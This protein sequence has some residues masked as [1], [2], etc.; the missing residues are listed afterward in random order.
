MSRNYDAS[1]HHN[2]DKTAMFARQAPAT[3]ENAKA[4]QPENYIYES[5]IFLLRT[6][7]EEEMS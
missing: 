2:S 5:Q 6:L 7:N 3:E 4:G 1:F